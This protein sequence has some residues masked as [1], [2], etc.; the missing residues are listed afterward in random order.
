MPAVILYIATSLDGYIAR[1]D[2]SFDWLATV[3]SQETDYGYAEFYAGIDAIAMGSRTYEQVLGGFDEWPYADKRVFVF[4]HRV[5]EAITPN[6]TF[7]AQSPAEFVS[8][9]D[10]AGVRTLWLEGGGELVASF[11]EHRLIDEYILSIVP[12]MLG[13]GIPL[14]KSPLPEHRLE[15]LES[16]DYATGLVQLHYRNRPNR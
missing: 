10:S 14:F 7:T 15:L 5:L 6:V 8:G 13:D 2:G 1:A 16:T 3:D 9:L 11:L 4:T 12:I